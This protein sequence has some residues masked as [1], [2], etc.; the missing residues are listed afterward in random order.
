MQS[1]TMTSNDRPRRQCPST[2]YKNPQ[3]FHSKTDDWDKG[4]ISA[5]Q[6]R[7]Q[8]TPPT[9]PTLLEVA[10]TTMSPIASSGV[11]NTADMEINVYPPLPSSSAPESQLQKQPPPPEDD[12]VVEILKALKD[13]HICLHISN[14]IDHA[15]NSLSM[16]DNVIAAL[17]EQSLEDGVT[18]EYMF[19]GERTLSLV[20]E[21]DS[22]IIRDP[23]EHRSTNTEQTLQHSNFVTLDNFQ[24]FQDCVLDELHSLKTSQQESNTHHQMPNYFFDQQNP[25]I[26]SLTSQIEFLQKIVT[27]QNEIIM[28]LTSNQKYYQQCACSIQQVAPNNNHQQLPTKQS[29][30][31][32][33]ATEIDNISSD[34]KSKTTDTTSKNTSTGQ[35]NNQKTNNNIKKQNSSNNSN[36]NEGQKDRQQVRKNVMI[37]GDSMLNAINERE[38]RKHHF[39]QVRNHPGAN[40]DDLLHHTRAHARKK[41]DA[42]ILLVGQNDISQNRHNASKNINQ[43]LD[44]YGNLQKVIR[45]MKEILP[46]THLAICEVTKRNDYTNIKQDVND[47]NQQF[48]QL[49]QREQIGFVSTQE[50]T[51]QDHL[52]GG[53]LHP[54][55]WGKE[56]L[57]N[58]L[59]K[60][61]STL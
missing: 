56:K 61:V 38:M 40:T 19:Q 6:E 29:V 37:V 42:M 20:E 60:Y 17:I 59:I 14:I 28:N 32:N 26:S 55:G 23:K 3:S 33:P 22:V 51:I 57:K 39:V 10:E 27:N 24:G 13:Q 43:K 53:G 54:N 8:N 7:Q 30:E 47:L 34:A 35:T 41:P 1:T 25:I 5:S 31:I 45:E 2:S 12:T 18:K 48:R 52:G 15:I 4:L 36:K 9:S 58:I 21:G 49:A 44:S 16:E 50:F 11:L 46:E